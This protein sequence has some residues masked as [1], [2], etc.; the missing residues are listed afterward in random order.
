MSEFW[1]LVFP[2]GFS[3]HCADVPISF[4][5]DGLA[6]EVTEICPDH[7]EQVRWQG[8]SNSSHILLLCCCQTPGSIMLPLLSPSTMD[9]I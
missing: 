6:Q 7:P 2:H 5:P 4:T 8:C 1:Y 9:R 3:S